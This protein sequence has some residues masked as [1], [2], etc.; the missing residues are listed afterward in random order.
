MCV[1]VF[2]HKIGEEKEGKKEKKKIIVWFCFVTYYLLGIK[3]KFKSIHTKGELT[4]FPNFLSFPLLLRH[5]LF[6]IFSTDLI[7]GNRYCIQCDSYKMYVIYLWLQ[8]TEECSSDGR[9]AKRRDESSDLQAVENINWIFFCKRPFK[10]MLVSPS[11]QIGRPLNCTWDFVCFP[12]AST[13]FPVVKTFGY[14]TPIVLSLSLLLRHIQW[15]LLLIWT[16]NC[17]GQ[18]HVHFFSS[19]F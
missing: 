8:F 17:L 10:F 4:I 12:Q 5:H 13:W 7:N 3:F 6:F 19:L 14:N 15:L 2:C 11:P 18:Q 1:C 9:G 16:P